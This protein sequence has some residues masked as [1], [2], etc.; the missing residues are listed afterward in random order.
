VANLHFTVDVH[1]QVNTDLSLS[2]QATGSLRNLLSARASITPDA[3]LT[4]GGRATTNLV[5]RND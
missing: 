4:I 1:A 5:G 2:L 3:L